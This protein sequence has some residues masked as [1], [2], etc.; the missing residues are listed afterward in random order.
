MPRRRRSDQISEYQLSQIDRQI[1]LIQSALAD[2]SRQLTP[3]RPRYDA[4]GKLNDDLARA[5]NVLKD[6]PGD[7][8]SLTAHF[9][10][11]G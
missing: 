6:R 7:Y 3:F 9:C 2:A 10:R 11:T 5:Q 8:R 1:G 4:T